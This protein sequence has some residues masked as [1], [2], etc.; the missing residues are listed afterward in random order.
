[1]LHRGDV[2]GEKEDMTVEEKGFK[3]NRRGRMKA[4]KTEEW[5]QTR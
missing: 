3:M 5:S 2:K 1:M 4:S